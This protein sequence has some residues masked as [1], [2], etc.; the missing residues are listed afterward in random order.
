MHYRGIQRKSLAANREREV[1]SISKFI[2]STNGDESKGAKS[3]VH[4]PRE[5]YNREAST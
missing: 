1:Y 4:V 5:T 2:V 3:R